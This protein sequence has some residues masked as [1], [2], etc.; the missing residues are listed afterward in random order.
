MIVYS[1]MSLN[2]ITETAGKIQSRV[3]ELAIPHKAS[4]CGDVVTVSQGVFI[5]QPEEQNRE[6]DFN[7][8]ADIALYHVK[9]DGRNSY[10]IETEFSEV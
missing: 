1:D 4:E 8:Q 6:W 9:R 7:A 5:R 10:R 2:E 3:R